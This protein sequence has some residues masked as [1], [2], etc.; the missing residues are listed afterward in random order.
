[1]INPPS[2]ASHK[3]ILAATDYFTRWTEAV[4]FRDATKASVLEFL[5]GIVTRFGVPSTIISD[6]AKAFVGTQ[7]S[8]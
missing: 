3:W 1:M 5:D 2:S 4:A 7:I 8:S 6:N